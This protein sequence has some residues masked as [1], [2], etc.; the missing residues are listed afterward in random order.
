LNDFRASA[1]RIGVEDG[2]FA[3][4]ADQHRVAWSRCQYFGMYGPRSRRLNVYS[5]RS[6]FA[7]WKLKAPSGE[8]KRQVRTAEVWLT[9][10]DGQSLLNTVQVL[11]VI[12]FTDALAKM[13]VVEAIP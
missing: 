11:I 12:P 4:V 8:K 1:I 3:P 10:N 5:N 13:L 2:T 6:R 7:P 9:V